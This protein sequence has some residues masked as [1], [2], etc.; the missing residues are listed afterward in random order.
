MLS[1]RTVKQGKAGLEKIVF[2][3]NRLLCVRFRLPLHYGGWQHI[4]PRLLAHMMEEPVSP[5]DAPR[6]GMTF[7]HALWE[8]EQQGDG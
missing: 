1:V 2:Y 7:N 5:T 6:T 4:P 8:G 3:L